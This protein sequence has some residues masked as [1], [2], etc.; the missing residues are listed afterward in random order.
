MEKELKPLFSLKQ[1]AE[2]CGKNYT[3]LKRYYTFPDFLPDPEYTVI[4]ENGRKFRK[5]T[6][7]EAEEIKKILDSVT[8]GD[9]AEYTRKLRRK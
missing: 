7:E 2:Y 8:Y 9:L 3:T 6:M 4:S 5:F 1:V